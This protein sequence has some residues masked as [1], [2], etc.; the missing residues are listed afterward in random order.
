[1]ADVR[2]SIREGRFDAF[3]RGD[4]RCRLGPGTKDVAS[5]EE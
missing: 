5:A 4:P 2:Q 1:M 3:R